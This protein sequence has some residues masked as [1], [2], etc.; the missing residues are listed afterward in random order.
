[1]C[2]A[3]TA[4]AGA[5][6]ARRDDAST[7]RITC[8]LTDEAARLAQEA[9][10][11]VVEAF[12]QGAGVEVDRLDV[13]LAARVR[14][15]SRDG[16]P[17]LD[18]DDDVMARLRQVV[19]RPDAIVVKSPGIAA[20]AAQV[21]SAI[22]ALRA[23][24]VAVPDR[25]EGVR[26]S[27]VNTAVRQ[28]T[29]IRRVA[30]VVKRHLRTGASNADVPAGARLAMGSRSRVAGLSDG[31]FVSSER[32]ITVR[33]GTTL[34][35]TWAGADGT[36]RVLRDGVA[37]GAGDVVDA[38]TMRQAALAA[39]LGE[40]LDTCRREG[41]LFA[42]PLKCTTLHV[43]DPAIFRAAMR[44]YVAPALAH[45]P[46]CLAR[47]GVDPEDGLGALAA[48][49]A[50]GPDDAALRDAMDRLR[51]HG[52]A[53]ARDATGTGRSTLDAP[54]GPS[55]AAWMAAAWQRGGCGL[56][57]DGLARDTL[58]V[59]PDR[60]ESAF[61]EVL[62][63]DVQAFGRPDRARLGA[64]TLVGLAAD[65][66]D[67]Y[68]AQDTT[69]EIERAGTVRVVD[70]D[71]RI[72]L[73][74]P[75]EA[76]DLWRLRRRSRRAIA[77][78]IACALEAG[79]RSR[80]PVTFW[81][82]RTRARDRETLRHLD[83][84]CPPL[85]RAA[86]GIEVL[87]VAEATRAMLRRLRR[88]DDG[89]AATGNVLRDFVGEWIGVA[90]VASSAALEVRTDLLAG[91]VLFEA[92]AGGTGPALARDFAHDG[93]LRWNPLGD[94]LAW[95]GALQAAGARPGRAHAAALGDALERAIA[96]LLAQDLLPTRQ[97]DGRD[98]RH[99]LVHLARLW[100]HEMSEA[101]VQGGRYADVAARLDAD[102]PGLLAEVDAVRR[103]ATDVGGSCLPVHARPSAAM[104][105]GRRF[106]AILRTLD[107][108]AASGPATA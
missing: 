99:T 33:D 31:D 44:A 21:A 66:A 77:H 10:L 60:G 71:G 8:C 59:R 42:L 38:S 57:A 56:D 92:G 7:V 17:S 96:G 13:S 54:G 50:R 62:L 61:F 86:R 14:A 11:P 67:D 79:R 104:A 102:L 94:L 53:L 105:P 97:A 88:G 68:G 27:V 2:R 85:E 15:A 3:R 87:D 52:P 46:A 1:M 103:G 34:R 35:I 89:V 72:V 26:G 73:E 51:R 80:A 30:P 32:A 48:A 106:A 22:A 55:V 23:E 16:M 83:A 90:E 25:L 41:L 49:A 29:S 82:D 12:V 76:G 20:T 84:A 74:H 24:G 100:A 4:E 45:D 64:V 81:L 70:A 101:P 107:G 40:T 36:T 93:H 58:F 95:R 9:L 6:G 28:G 39:F 78:W 5:S 75:V 108:G 69:F 98:L 63:D 91:S 18:R 37:V 47:A 19:S 43:S 65:A